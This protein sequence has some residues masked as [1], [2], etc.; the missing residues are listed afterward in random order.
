MSQPA[1]GIA[2]EKQSCAQEGRAD[3]EAAQSGAEPAT[4]DG[5]EPEPELGVLITGG[6]VTVG[7]L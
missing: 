4:Q 7:L 5:V 2:E 1:L 6:V 3:A